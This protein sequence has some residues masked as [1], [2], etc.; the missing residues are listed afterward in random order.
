MMQRTDV[1]ARGG[2]KAPRVDREV[3]RISELAVP[4]MLGVH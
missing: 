4:M 1:E 3:R 2:T